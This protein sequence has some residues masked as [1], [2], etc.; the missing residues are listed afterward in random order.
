MKYKDSNGEWK[1]LTVLTGDTLPIGSIIPYGSDISP[2]GWLFCEGQE[3]SRN[4]YTEL[5][6]II[7]TKYGEG[8]GN[9][10]F[11]IPN[12]K[13][14]IPVGKNDE[15]IDFDTIGEI[16]GE[17]THQL[18][19]EEIPS[20]T[21]SYKTTNGEPG[22]Y[23]A[24]SSAATTKV[25]DLNTTETDQTNAYTGGGQAHNNIQPYQVTTYIIKAQNIANPN[26][27]TPDY[28]P[29]G[30]VV[31]YN[32]TEVPE[33]W[34][35]I[36]G[37]IVNTLEGNET[38]KAPSVAT[39]N[40]ALNNLVAEAVAE[41]AVNSLTV[42]GLDIIKDGGIYDIVIAD[43]STSTSS[44]GH[45]LQCNGMESGYLGKHYYDWKN[46]GS[47][48]HSQHSHGFGY[49]NGWD[50]GTSLCFSHGVITY[51]NKDW[52][53]GKIWMSSAMSTANWVDVYSRGTLY[54]QNVDNITSLTIK[55]HDGDLIG[56]GSYIRVYKR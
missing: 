17:K 41:T 10:T 24:T 53:D 19:V 18:T 9:T 25:G 35:E 29:V 52:I 2:I 12:L 26:V 14:R 5:F 40:N 43:F 48:T 13:G 23:G 45:T 7:G 50:V 39:V 42:S 8:D 51:F 37:D 56:V 20:H 33:G 21:H 28:V 47:F 30:A 4:D 38:N 6:S 31:E 11:N 32:G 46:S 16:G 34:E 27:I 36:D 55:P 15:D 44:G 3:I 1:T 49:V 22:P 54:S